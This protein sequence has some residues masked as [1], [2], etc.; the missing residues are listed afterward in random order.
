MREILD[1]FHPTVIHAITVLD[2]ELN[3]IRS[4]DSAALLIEEVIL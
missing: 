4:V 3:I 2:R 1:Y